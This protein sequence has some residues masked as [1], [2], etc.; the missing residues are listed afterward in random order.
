MFGVAVY[1]SLLPLVGPFFAGLI[2][3]VLFV[4][5]AAG[6]AYAAVNRLKSLL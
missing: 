5:A 6:M 1:L 2:A 4:G 3:I